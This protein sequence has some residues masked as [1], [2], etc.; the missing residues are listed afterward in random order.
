MDPGMREL[1]QQMDWPREVQ[2]AR[3]GS[4]ESHP[5]PSQRSSCCRHLEHPC[6]GNSTG[7]RALTR[8]CPFSP[9][10]AAGRRFL[11]H[12]RLPGAEFPLRAHPGVTSGPDRG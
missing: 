10:N 1:R 8:I 5:A 4:R 11:L 9:G 7:G 2:E 12:A 6:I 3:E